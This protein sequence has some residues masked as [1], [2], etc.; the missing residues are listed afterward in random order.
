MAG[1]PARDRG[2]SAQATVRNLQAGAGVRTADLSAGGR[3]RSGRP[4]PRPQRRPRRRKAC[5]KPKGQARV[6]VI[7]TAAGRAWPA[8]CPG[9]RGLAWGLWAWSISRFS[10]RDGSVNRSSPSARYR[11]T[12]CLPLPGLFGRSVIAPPAENSINP[13]EFRL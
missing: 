13:V 7:A 11:P 10:R 8:G 3:V 2:R 1:H 9:S 6:H 5:G 4:A 12:A